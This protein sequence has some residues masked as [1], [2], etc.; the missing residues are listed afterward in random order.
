MT[1][2]RRLWHYG[3]VRFAIPALRL[4]ASG[5]FDPKYLHGRFFDASPIGWVWIWQSF[6]TQ[7]VLRI[8]SH[9]PWPISASCRIDEPKGIQFH[10]DDLQNFMHFG[11]YFSNARGGIITLGKG[12]LIAP[13][14]G[15]I[16]TNHC[17]TDPTQHTQPRNVTIGKSCWLGM[18]CVILPGVTLG[19]NTV[20]GAGAIVSKSF[21]EGRCVLVGSPARPIRHLATSPADCQEA[22]PSMDDSL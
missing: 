21:P 10:E 3:L 22:Q 6:W 14:V 8:N 7:K 1:I 12:T 11:C 15:I 17:T 4:L 19:D 2:K 5:F 16:T 9:V 20:V 18:N 13:N